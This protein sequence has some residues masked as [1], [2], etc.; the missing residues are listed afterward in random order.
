MTPINTSQASD[1]SF[2][3]R[4]DI[5]QEIFPKQ[6]TK[7]EIRSL[8]DIMLI[9]QKKMNLI[10]KKQK[11]MIQM[12]YIFYDIRL[13]GSEELDPYQVI[14]IAISLFFPH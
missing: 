12:K 8:K 13:S 7:I 11:K 2:A 9:S 1:A 14:L 6:K 3:R 10:E 5:L 4:W